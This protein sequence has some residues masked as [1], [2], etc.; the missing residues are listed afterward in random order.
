MPSDEADLCRPSHCLLGESLLS[1]NLN[2]KDA[3]AFISC[4]ASSDYGLT[5]AASVSSLRTSSTTA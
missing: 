2:V 1:A 3:E 4:E 5:I